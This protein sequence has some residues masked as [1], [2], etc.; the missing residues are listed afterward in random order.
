MVMIVEFAEVTAARAVR[1]R[2]AGIALHGI[3]R[4]VLVVGICFVAFP[5]GGLQMPFGKSLA[6]V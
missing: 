6:S 4:V 3:V 1:Q 5:E 2:Y